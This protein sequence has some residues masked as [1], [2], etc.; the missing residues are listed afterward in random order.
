MHSE[1]VAC[2]V[3]PRH[4][5]LSLYGDDIFYGASNRL[6]RYNRAEGRVTQALAVFDAGHISCIS[7]AGAKYLIGGTEGQL[8]VYDTADQEVK[9]HHQIIKGES[10]RFAKTIEHKNSTVAFVGYHG[11]LKA[12]DM[13][14]GLEMTE[15]DVLDFGNNLL[16][17]FECGVYDGRLLA[18]ISTCDKEIHVY[19]LT[20]EQR[21]EYLTSLVGYLNKVSSLDIKRMD[22]SLYLLSGGFDNFI[23]M[24]KVCRDPTY[25][26]N[27]NIYPLEGLNAYIELESVLLGHTEAITSVK[28]VGEG[29]ISCGLD[30]GILIWQL[31][32]ELLWESNKRLGQLYGNKNAF[33][34]LD[35]TPA[36]DHIVAYTYTGACYS[37]VLEDGDYKSVGEFTGH[38]AKVTDVVWSSKGDFLASCSTDQTTRVYC[39]N[40]KSI[41]KELS[42]AQ[43]HGYNLNSITM[44][45]MG[46]EYCDLLVCGADEKILRI[47]EPPVHFINFL[48]TY[49]SKAI[50]LY[51]PDK[52]EEKEILLS[53]HPLL[54]RSVKE[55]GQEVLGLMTKAFK[56]E[57]KSFYYDEEEQ[58]SQV[59]LSLNE[60]GRV[61]TEDFLCSYT[62]W[63]EV[64][65]FYGHGYEISVVRARGDGHVLVSACK[66]QTKEHSALIFWDLKNYKV[67]YVLEA[68]NYTVLDIKFTTGGLVTV[69]RDRQVVYYELKDNRYSVA[70]AVNGHTR[71]I[72]SVAYCNSSKMICTGSRDKCIKLWRLEGS[73]LAE[74]ARLSCQGVVRAVEFFDDKIILVGLE[75]GNLAICLYAEGKLELYKK[76][77]IHG[78]AINKIRRHPDA[79]TGLFATCSDDCSVSVFS[80][81]AIYK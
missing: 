68:H 8:A 19:E 40:P 15:L 16:E 57:K 6:M 73:K 77:K 33:F 5:N 30:C 14:K 26:D 54:Y 25:K 50:R 78:K 39:P 49:G 13:D 81:D 55:S 2:N 56:E 62:L 67:D 47:L 11:M 27:K 4:Q 51:T 79:K 9:K 52:S 63:P 59:T 41:W 1:F 74:V 31:N 36:L 42:R 7:L 66:S 20:G 61:P 38:F 69:G 12:F 37:W 45:S 53:D 48:N 10:I 46:E 18:F 24:W 43:I 60:Y 35:A 58:K 44:L 28:W 72:N 34:G 21:F 23:R 70:S 75:D 17:A 76:I 22:D 32:N 80:L 65:K 29:F 3:N 71:L 64:N